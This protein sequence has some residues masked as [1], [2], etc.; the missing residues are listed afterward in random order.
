MARLSPALTLFRGNRRT[1]CIHPITST[2]LHSLRT[3]HIILIIHAHT[4]GR[5]AA[6][7]D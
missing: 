7:P 2:I 5:A 4:T 3:L 1:P 6:L